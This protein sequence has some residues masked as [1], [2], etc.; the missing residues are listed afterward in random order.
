MGKVWQISVVLIIAL[1]F[2]VHSKSV[3]HDPLEDT[4][5]YRL[6]NTTEPVRYELWMESQ[7]HNGD[8]AFSG[9]VAITIRVLESTRQIQL[10]SVG[11][12]IHN[13]YYY[14]LFS[15]QKT[16]E[17]FPISRTVEDNQIINLN[18]ESMLLSGRY[19]VVTLE[20]TGQLQNQIRGFFYS[21][22][23]DDFGRVS[24]IAAT[25]FQHI[26]AR[27]AFPCY[28]E[29]RYRTPF[30]IHITHGPLYHAVSN[31]PVLTTENQ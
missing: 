26:F 15:D 28:D 14:E 21:R 16:S 23:L 6:S 2:P 27:W 8:F 9:R 10:N 25:A 11:L 3:E 31:M 1:L 20:F 17:I 24:Y 18:T 29:P 19:Y 30:T 4:S 5:T 7:I 22:Y 12:D 13:L